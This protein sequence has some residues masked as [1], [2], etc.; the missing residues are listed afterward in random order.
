VKRIFCICAVLA[1]SACDSSAPTAAANDAATAPTPAVQAAAPAAAPANPAADQ[2]A[3]IQLEQDYAKALIAKDR[4]FLM[5]FYAPDW[6]GG[7][8]MGFWGK[9]TMLKSVL[10]DDRYVVKSMVVR[11]LKVRVVG[12]AAVVQGVDDE[13][14][15]VD[16]K[17]TSGKWAFT[18][19]FERRDGRWVAVAG[20]TS[21]I[22]P[23]VAQ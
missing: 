13:V 7:N 17:D 18:D 10:N 15:S 22:E 12:D 19:V 3:L 2:A 9:A 4:A 5:R 11:D 14:T 20:H 23:S 6:R 16:G 1:L 8:W 21:K